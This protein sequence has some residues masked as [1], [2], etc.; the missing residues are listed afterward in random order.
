[1][2]LPDKNS[3]KLDEISPEA[4]SQEETK[5]TIQQWKRRQIQIQNV[6]AQILLKLDKN[7]IKQT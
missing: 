2:L 4:S 3:L 5:N 6:D 7:R 1:M